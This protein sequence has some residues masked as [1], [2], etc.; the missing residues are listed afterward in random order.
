MAWSIPRWTL[1]VILVIIAMVGIVWFAMSW[2]HANDIRS[3]F[4]IPKPE[5]EGF[6]LAVTSNEAGRIRVD[7]TPE[8]EREGLWG[9]EG[10]AAYAQ[11]ST[12]VRLDGETVERGVRTLEGEFASGDVARIDPDAFTGDPFSAHRIAWE[13]IV[14]PSEIGPHPGWFVDGRRATWMV[15]VH[16]KGD[17]RL[18]ESLRIIPSLVEQGFPVMVVTIRNDV[19]ATPSAS[20]MRMWGLE[21]WRDVDAAVQ[22]GL[23]KG[24]RDFVL[25]G[26]GFGAGIVS[27]FLHESDQIGSIRG[28][29]FD[30]PVVDLE[31]AVEQWSREAGTPGP[32]GWLG[33]RLVTV[34]F[35]MEWDLL[36]Q[37]ERAPEFDVPMLILH[38]GEDPVTSPAT[39]EEFTAAVEPLAQRQRFEQGGHT[40]LW[41]IDQFRYEAAVRTWL[42][43]L[44]GTE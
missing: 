3:T 32:V 10:E 20:G 34:R 29:I 38:G 13:P 27:T 31:Q 17:D 36:D 30:S 6:P 24:A 44:L 15:F 23:R 35:G 14:I 43:D 40:D 1:R 12:I 5:A 2:M 11:V 8:S 16:G 41:N 26:S 4:L 39:I 21:E 25:I 22:L 33:R 7:R 37:I 9:L 42:S 28:V 19:G 18:S